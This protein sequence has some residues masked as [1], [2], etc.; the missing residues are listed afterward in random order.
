MPVPATCPNR[1]PKTLRLNWQVDNKRAALAASAC[2]GDITAM[3]PGNMF[4]NGKLQTRAAH[5]A[6]AGLVH[7]VK[8]LEQPRQMFF[9]NAHA[10]IFNTD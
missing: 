8:P 6:A 9:G 5:C 7:A 10:L 3:R 1:I 2:H 4:D